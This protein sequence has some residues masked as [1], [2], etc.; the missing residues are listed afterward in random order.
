MANGGTWRAQ[1]FWTPKRGHAVEEYEDAWS[2]DPHRGVFAIADGATESS[3]AAEWARLLTG[4]FVAA[5]AADP[6][7]WLVR[8]PE[9]QKQWRELVS[10]RELPW[11]AE[12]KLALGAFATFLG[13]TL[14]DDGR[15]QALAVGDSCL[16]HLRAEQALLTFPLSNSDEFGNAPWLLGSRNALTDEW[17]GQAVRLHQGEWTAGDR[18]WLLTDAVAHSVLLT[19]EDD[20][21]QQVVLPFDPTPESFTE[22][23]S[24]ER[25][26]GRLRN[27]DCTWMV[28]DLE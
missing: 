1:V 25:D 17:R 20:P 3:F 23:V 11:Y 9:L 2:M 8:L 16:I 26:R 7:G 4:D 21:V 19:M 27:D 15:F 6:Q 22:W 24:A 14:T 12:E 28:I 10:G 18:L 13:V 5:G